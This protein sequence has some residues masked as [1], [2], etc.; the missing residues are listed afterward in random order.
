MK[1]II[2]ENRLNDIIFKYLNDIDW[3]IADYTDPEWGDMTRLFFKSKSQFPEDAIFEAFENEDCTE[4][5][6]ED[7]EECPTERV[8]MVN[9]PFYLQLMSLFSLNSIE[10]KKILIKWY[11]SYTHETIDDPKIGFI[12]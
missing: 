7:D 2:T 3:E 10:T 5:S 1:Y 4:V 11:E 9:K 12:D 6:I 8:L